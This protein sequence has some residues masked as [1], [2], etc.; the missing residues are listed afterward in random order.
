MKSLIVESG[1]LFV[2]VAGGAIL[3]L[4]LGPGTVHASDVASLF[5][6]LSLALVTGLAWRRLVIDRLG[7]VLDLRAPA[8]AK[9]LV[10]FWRCLL[11]VTIQYAATVVFVC[12][13]CVI[14]WDPLIL[15]YSL[16]QRLRLTA[17]T[18]AA[19]IVL[20]SLRLYWDQRANDFGAREN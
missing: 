5:T 17:G 13:Y 2:V 8:P 4:F 16:S 12:L 11:I 15:P 14:T 9:G 19:I 10:L 18:W 6:V 7:R 1:L 20:R 3:F